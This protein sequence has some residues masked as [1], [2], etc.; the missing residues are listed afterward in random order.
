MANREKLL[1]IQFCRGIAATLVVLYHAG[2]MLALPQYAGHVPLNGVFN[3][4]NSGVDFFFVLS[5]FIIYFVHRGDIGRPE[6]LLSYIYSRATRI[7]PPYWFVTGIVVA[8]AFAKRDT[9]SPDPLHLI[10]SLLLVP[11]PIEPVLQ[12]GWT[13]VCEMLF[14]IGFAIAIG[15]RFAGRVVL[16]IWLVLIL[17]SLAFGVHLPVSN[18]IASYQIQFA[19]GMLAAFALEKWRFPWPTMVAI[20]GVALFAEAAYLLDTGSL[21]YQ[22]AAVRVLLGMASMLVIHGVARL[23]IDGRIKVGAAAAF[24]G[25]ASYSIY[26]IHT[27]AIGFV[28]SRF[29]PAGVLSAWPGAML[30]LV[31]V[32]AVG[33]GGLLYISVEK[34][35][36]RFFRY[37]RPAMPHSEAA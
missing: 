25:S 28:L 16:L 11:Q 7:Y 15:A 36:L 8:I 12:V 4:G 22:S 2:R 20:G 6:R 31:A 33:G 23:E 35:M 10:L 27:I 1:G 24:L 32:L 21:A 18:T 19:M 29:A 17:A 13:L 26:L 9:G 34:P 3:F 14:Y 30:M 37:H 5:G